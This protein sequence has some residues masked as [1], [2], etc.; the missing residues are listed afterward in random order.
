MTHIVYIELSSIL[1][2]EI[3]YQISRHSRSCY[4][5]IP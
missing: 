2:G 3:P 5:Q 4:L 1:T